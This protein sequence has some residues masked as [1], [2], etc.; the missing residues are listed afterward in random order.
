MIGDLN[1]R[2]T[3]TSWGSTKDAGGG[4]VATL[5]TSYQIWAKVEARSGM[6]FTGEQQQVWN[7]DYKVTFRYE[8]SRVVTSN[9]TIDYDGKRLS[10]KSISYVD[11]G[12]RKYCICKCSATELN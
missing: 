6:P 1:R 12:N 7:Y 5:N 3:L 9:F 2:I 10:I 4:P 8:K 11:E